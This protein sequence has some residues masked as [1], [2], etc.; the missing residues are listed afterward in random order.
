MEL[1]GHLQHWQVAEWEVSEAGDIEETDF[2]GAL[3]EIPLRKLHLHMPLAITTLQNL[4][5]L[6]SVHECLCGNILHLAGEGA[7][8]M[9]TT[10]P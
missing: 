4:A 2:V 3:P 8:G 1:G 7:S 6:A 5:C 9:R 10:Q